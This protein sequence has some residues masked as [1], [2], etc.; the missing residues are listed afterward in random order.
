MEDEKALDFVPDAKGEPLGSLWRTVAPSLAFAGVQASWAIQVRAF[1]SYAFHM[2][3]IT[4]FRTL[5]ER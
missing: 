4:S 5:T 3:D 2:A 1:G